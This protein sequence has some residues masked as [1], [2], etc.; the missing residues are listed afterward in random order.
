MKKAPKK[1]ALQVAVEAAKKRAAK[2]KGFTKKAA[3]EAAVAPHPAPP[4]PPPKWD[5]MCS[6]KK[7]G[8]DY[9]GQP[10]DY[11]ADEDAAAET[12]QEAANILKA[13]ELPTA[14]LMLTDAE[15]V[16]AALVEGRHLFELLSTTILGSA[17][18]A[19]HPIVKVEHALREAERLIANAIR[20]SS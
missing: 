5:G 14:K 7:H 6:A 13:S 17:C 15:K 16:R 19:L 3:I 11:C 1:T 4:A 12:Q 20:L 9:E 18:S 8:L 2:S 10:C